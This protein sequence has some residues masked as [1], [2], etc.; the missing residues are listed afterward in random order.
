M[1]VF[2]NAASGGDD[3]FRAFSFCLQNGGKSTCSAGLFPETKII[4]RERGDV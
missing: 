2:R 1:M 4:F 3:D